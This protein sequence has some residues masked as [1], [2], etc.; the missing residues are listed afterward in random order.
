MKL[1]ARDG[2]Y[3]QIIL[4]TFIFIKANS[5]A[6]PAF[7]VFS[8]FSAGAWNSSMVRTMESSATGGE[9]SRQYDLM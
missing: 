8:A 2:D 4:S 7:F 5:V 3:L 1:P 6:K 9:C